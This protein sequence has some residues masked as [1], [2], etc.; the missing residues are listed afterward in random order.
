LLLGPVAASAA[1]TFYRDIRPILAQH[2]WTCHRSG[3]IGP[4]ALETYQQA[5]PWAKAIEKAVLLKQM[6]PWFADPAFGK[7]SNDPSLTAQEIA[8][9]SDWVKSGAPEGSP[10]EGSPKNAPAPPA[11]RSGWLLGE[12]DAVVS[13]P[14]PFAVPKTGEIEY[15]YII[16]PTGFTQDRWVQK[17]EVHPG[18]RA[19]VH[20][21]VVYIREPG[22]PWLADRPK[23]IPFTVPTD[24][25]ESVTHSDILFTYTPGNQSDEWR[26][27]MAK[28]VKA[29]S[30][31]VFQMHYTADPAGG[32][33]QT[34]IGMVF[35]Q[36]APAERVLTLQIGNDHFLI[37]PRVPNFRVAAWGTLPND[38][39]LLS[40]YPH[41]HLRGAGFEY[42]ILE[43]S[44]KASTLLKVNHYD[45]HWQ[46]TY[47]LA[48]PLPLR[49]GTRIEVAG[50]FDNTA[51]N[52]RNPD[53]DSAV[54][55]GFQSAEEM[56][57]GFFDVAVPAGTDK[58]AYFVREQR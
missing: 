1:P 47:R 48:E 7:F 12:P 23:G 4:M 9:L 8:T 38:A 31:L 27:G 20:H 58:A 49:A 28:F 18:N 21:A 17:V 57:I 43:P 26:P 32:T 46:L 14:R 39:K 42:R 22:A 15:Q 52:P 33:D 50:T 41:M 35:A 29:G 5:R 40:L 19:A 13:M 11:T 36:Q 3:G 53:P 44:G 34:R 55:F 30:D 45:F 54:R 56:M 25:P 51:R 10:P 6:P 24:N 37:P 16:V 2:C